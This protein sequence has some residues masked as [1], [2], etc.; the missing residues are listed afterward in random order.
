MYIKTITGTKVLYFGVT[1]DKISTLVI[2]NSHIYLCSLS[3]N[4]SH[5]QILTFCESVFLLTVGLG[6]RLSLE[7]ES[8]VF[9]GRFLQI[10]EVVL[11]TGAWNTGAVKEYGMNSWTRVVSVVRGFSSAWTGSSRSGWY[12]AGSSGSSN[13]LLSSSCSVTGGLGS[14]SNKSGNMD[15]RGIWL[16]FCVRLF[17]QKYFLNVVLNFRD[18][19]VVELACGNGGIAYGGP[20]PLLYFP[21]N[22]FPEYGTSSSWYSS[23]CS[24]NLWSSVEWLEVDKVGYSWWLVHC[25]NFPWWVCKCHSILGHWCFLFLC[26]WLCVVLCSGSNQGI[27]L[28]RVWWVLQGLFGRFLD[29]SVIALPGLWVLGVVWQSSMLWWSVNPWERL[30]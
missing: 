17:S 1:K 22:R 18:Q 24:C 8:A 14:G 15:S 16:C 29:K 5:K 11:V 3:H 19:S 25:S 26:S 7:S 9:A 27:H 20:G 13:S 4:L 30:L 2:K 12:S 10:G 6:W 23:E 28:P 21:S